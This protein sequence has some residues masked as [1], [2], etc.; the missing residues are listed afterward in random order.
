M[1]GHRHAQFGYI[2]AGLGDRELI[3]GEVLIP[4]HGMKE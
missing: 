1:C 2:Q 4:G 3:A